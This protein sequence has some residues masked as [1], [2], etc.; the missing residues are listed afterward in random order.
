MSFSGGMIHVTGTVVNAGQSQSPLHILLHSTPGQ[1]THT[2]NQVQGERAGCLPSGL[3][4]SSFGP[5]QS[6]MMLAVQ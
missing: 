1:A 5:L 4:E 2:P 3:L 6:A